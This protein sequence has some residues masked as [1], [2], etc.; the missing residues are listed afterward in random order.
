MFVTWRTQPSNILVTLLCLHAEAHFIKSAHKLDLS[1]VSLIQI[2]VSVTICVMHIRYK[3]IKSRM[4]WVKVVNFFKKLFSGGYAIAEDQTQ[5]KPSTPRLTTICNSC[6]IGLWCILIS[7]S[8][9]Y[10]HG[11]RYSTQTHKVSKRENSF[12]SYLF[13][14]LVFEL[15]DYA[16]QNRHDSELVYQTPF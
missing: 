14:A 15:S 1:S 13:R 7:A 12:L 9:R 16:V 4:F 2:D 6:S 11:C 3:S 10:T 8:T 5:F